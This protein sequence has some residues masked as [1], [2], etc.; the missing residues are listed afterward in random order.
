MYLR[1]LCPPNSICIIASLDVSNCESGKLEF[2]IE[3]FNLDYQNQLSCEELH[4]C[5]LS[6]SDLQMRYASPPE[7]QRFFC[8]HLFIASASILNCCNIEL[9]SIRTI[10]AHYGIAFS[11]LM[12]LAIG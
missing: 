8:Y 1:K 11:N 2:L 4:K 12:Y 5:A 3:V 10:I 9:F 7:M 6:L